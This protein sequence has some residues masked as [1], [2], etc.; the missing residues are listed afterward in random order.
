MEFLGVQNGFLIVN[1]CPPHIRLN[2]HLSF[3]IKLLKC[4]SR[5][6]MG[7]LDTLQGREKHAGIKMAKEYLE[8]KP[9]D[10]ESRLSWML[11]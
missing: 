6:K 8:K 9:T 7:L 11:Q 2:L 5:F 10:R 3:Q 4:K 1:D